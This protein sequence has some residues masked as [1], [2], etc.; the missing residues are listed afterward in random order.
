MSEEGDEINIYSVRYLDGEKE[1]QP[2][3]SRAGRAV[4]VYANGDRYEGEYNGLKQRHGYGTYKYVSATAAEGEEDDGAAA[5]NGGAVYEGQWRLGIKSGRGRMTYANGEVYDGMWLDNSRN[6]RGTYRYANGDVFTGR[7]SGGVKEGAGAYKFAVNGVQLVGDWKEG[8]FVSGKQVNSDLSSLHSSWNGSTPTGNGIYFMASGNQIEGKYAAPQKDGDE[9]ADED[10]EGDQGAGAQWQPLANGL[11]RSFAKYD[12]LVNYHE[13]DPS[14]MQEMKEEVMQISETDRVDALL[15]SIFQSIDTSNDGKI[16]V[17]E[18]SKIGTGIYRRIGITLPDT[19]L[20][21]L[22]L[23][24]DLEDETMISF[25]ELKDRLVDSE[26]AAKVAREHRARELRSLF[27]FADKDNKGSVNFADLVASLK[28]PESPFRKFYHDFAD[29]I[30]DIFKAL[31][32]DDD[33][34]V[35]WAEFA[36]GFETAFANNSCGAHA[37]YAKEKQKEV[38]ALEGEEI[39]LQAPPTIANI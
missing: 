6:G 11:Q 1:T 30:H 32:K 38:H 34:A 24:T 12:D 17:L 28:D 9:A 21:E 22:N 2:W 18:L 13:A 7:W 37:K 29:S 33:G 31:D 15:Q 8:V 3:L 4:V 10:A 19:S 20:A 39:D 26:A 14:D 27:A 23:F 5:G 36:N 35:D 16:S 25:A